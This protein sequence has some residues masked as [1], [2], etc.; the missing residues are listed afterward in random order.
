MEITTLGAGCF[1]CV[2]A[3]Y[4]RLRGVKQVTS[5][6]A[7]GNVEN[8]SYEEVST[9]TTGHAE[10]CQIEFDPE[11]ITFEELLSVFFR[12]HDPTTLNRQGND[13]GPQYRSVIFYHSDQQRETAE[14]IKGELVLSKR[15]SRPIVTEIAPFTNFYPAE[16]YHHDYFSRNHSQPYCRLVI[17]PKVAKFEKEFEHLLV[18]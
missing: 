13:I 5:G 8:P 14:R 1:W 9:G 2:E 11:D 4:K 17:D 12:I 7:G 3:I 6:Y 10:V 18:R 15:Y 16:E